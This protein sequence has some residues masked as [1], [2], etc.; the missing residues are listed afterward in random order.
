MRRPTG[1]SHRRLGDARLPRSPVSRLRSRT[2]CSILAVILPVLFVLIVP[3][4]KL[5]PRHRGQ[6]VR[7][8][9]AVLD[10]RCGA[11]DHPVRR[12]LDHGRGDHRGAQP[13]VGAGARAPS[14]RGDDPGLADAV[15][16]DRAV[17]PR[18]L[19]GAPVVARGAGALAV[20]RDPP[21]DRAPRL[22]Q[23]VP[24][25]PVRRRHRR[26]ARGVPPGRRLRR[27][28]HRRA[29]R[30]AVPHR[31]VPPRQRPLAVAGRCIVS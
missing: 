20:P 8:P 5:F 14:A 1:A 22:D 16:R 17:R 7:R 6:R 25:P 30:R 4:E 21:L 11:H 18:G 23:R 3:F 27:R 15:R 10:V 28:V 9:L 12:R 2:T 13:R 19:L 26:P 31:A 29:G 24:R